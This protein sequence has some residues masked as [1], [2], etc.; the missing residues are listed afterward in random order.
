MWP[1]SHCLTYFLKGM[2]PSEFLTRY[3]LAGSNLLVL[4]PP[5]VASVPQ[6]KSASISGKLKGKIKR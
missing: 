5:R 4:P 3:S 6:G 1:C 2:T